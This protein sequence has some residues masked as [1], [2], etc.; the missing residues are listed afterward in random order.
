VDGSSVACGGWRVDPDARQAARM[1]MPA[2]GRVAIAR[3]GELTRKG[4]AT[5]IRGGHTCWPTICDCGTLPRSGE[6]KKAERIAMRN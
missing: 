6:R 3:L 1:T 4:D 2:R 5:Q